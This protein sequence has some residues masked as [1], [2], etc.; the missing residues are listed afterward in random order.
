M[1]TIPWDFP[2]EVGFF[3]HIPEM[4]INRIPVMAPTFGVTFLKGRF[5]LK[6]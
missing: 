3:C 5:S 6:N 1:D 2:L 4:I